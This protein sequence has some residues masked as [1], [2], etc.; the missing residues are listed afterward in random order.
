MKATSDIIFIRASLA[1]L[2][3]EIKK[4][5]GLINFLSKKIE[6]DEIIALI[7]TPIDTS[8]IEGE[9]IKRLIV[10]H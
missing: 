10:E 8:G 1:P 4:D 9:K 6:F 2:A 7:F 5:G 3:R